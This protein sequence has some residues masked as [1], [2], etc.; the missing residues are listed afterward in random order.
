MFVVEAA[1][2]K[3]TTPG[4]L[5]CKYA[6]DT[7]IIIPAGNSPT[8][9]SE[10]DHIHSRVK[11]NNLTL[12]RSKTVEAIFTD[13]KSKRTAT[14]PPPLPGITWCSTL[15]MLRVTITYGLSIAEHIKG[16]ITSCLETL[17][18]LKC[19]AFPWHSPFCCSWSFF[20]QWSLPNSVMRLVLGAVYPWPGTCNK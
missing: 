17:H 5:R 18:A 6:G 3:A 12:S 16:V 4:N 2:L 7:Y 1:D 11:L 13:K 19:P 15:K 14:P 9:T 10:L 20:E 8:R